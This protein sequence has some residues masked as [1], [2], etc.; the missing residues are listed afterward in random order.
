MRLLN[1]KNL[2]HRT[3]GLRRKNSVSPKFAEKYNYPE[4][5]LEES[6]RRQDQEGTLCLADSVEV[7]RVEIRKIALFPSVHDKFHKV[8]LFLSLRSPR[9]CASVRTYSFG[10]LK[11]QQGILKW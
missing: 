10:N 3:P 6:Q 2:S 1:S 4:E 8:F 7:R 11:K 5:A 9:L